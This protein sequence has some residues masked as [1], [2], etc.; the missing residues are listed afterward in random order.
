MG[1][2]A[3]LALPQEP[4]LFLLLGA[5]QSYA[6]LP[7]SVEGAS[8]AATEATVIRTGRRETIA[9][10]VCEHVTVVMARDSTD[11]CRTTA[12]GRFL[13]PALADRRSDNGSTW[14][15]AM[16]AR[17][18]GADGFPLKITMPDGQVP[19]LVT[20]I[21]RKRLTDDLFTVPLTYTK[22][23]LPSRR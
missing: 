22:M 20:R 13:N 15:G 23:R 7:R 3:L 16:A 14:S 8:G 11:L 19:W 10:V 9:G 17:A 12:L 6:E 18:L 1:P 4:V 5:S 2:V 21:E